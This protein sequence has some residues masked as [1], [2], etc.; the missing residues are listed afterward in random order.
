MGSRRARPAAEQTSRPA[1][2]QPGSPAARQPSSPAAQQRGSPAAQQPGSPAGDEAH[3]RRQR[4]RR[5]Q[6]GRHVG[7]Q[8]YKNDDR[9]D[10]K[11][12]EA[13]LARPRGR[14][15]SDCRR[16][17]LRRTRLVATRRHRAER[18]PWR[19]TRE[20]FSWR[21]RW[22]RRSAP[23]CSQ[24]SAAC[25]SAGSPAASTRL[26]YTQARPGR[27][28]PPATVTAALTLTRRRRRRRP[29]LPA[30]WA[31]CGRRGARASRRSWPRAAWPP[32]STC[33]CWRWG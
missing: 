20:P 1:A 10:V 11:Q 31:G 28:S 21:W 6:Q 30:C 3:R 7:A 5:R 19:W 9:R 17:S 25:G 2:R 29:R 27:G 8:P 23:A 15:A 12:R 22:M 16:A 26:G 18:K 4:R 32:R 14:C 24:R 33:A 13:L